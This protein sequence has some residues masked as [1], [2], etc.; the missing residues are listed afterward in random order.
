MYTIIEDKKF[1]TAKLN[2]AEE[3]WAQLDKLFKG[4]F[5]KGKLLLP[6]KKLYS[7]PLVDMA[8][9]IFEWLG[10]ETKKSIYVDFNEDIE[11]AGLYFEKDGTHFILVN[12]KHQNNRFEAAAI[13]AHE[14][15]HFYLIGEMN[16]RL[17]ETLDNEQF[18][19][20][21]TIYT[22]LG[23][24]VMNGFE[25]QSGWAVTAIGLMFGRLMVQTSS[26]SF[27]YYKPKQYG[28][29]F[30]SFVDDCKIGYSS[31]SGYFLPWTRHFLPASLRAASISSK[32]KSEMVQLGQKSANIANLKQLGL[33]VVLIPV[34]IL[35]MS[36]R[37]GGSSSSSIPDSAKTELTTLKSEVETLK[38]Q[39]TS[40]SESLDAREGSVDR[41]S[42]YAVDSYNE[43]VTACNGTR[44]KYSS[45]VDSYNA[46]VDKYKN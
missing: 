39:Y 19:D 12:Q 17:E 22:G 37:T 41:T 35:F 8:S 42:Q 30:K 21:A 13:L 16:F 11:P 6:D 44:E 14:I 40:C 5:K 27:G 33:V 34:A 43:D 31:F 15:M 20:M 9:E 2:T 25:Y 4:K 18:T 29:M 3:K 36:W 28:G 24:V 10:I 1:R 32:N 23:I 45:A 7:L 26:M 46:L 38:S